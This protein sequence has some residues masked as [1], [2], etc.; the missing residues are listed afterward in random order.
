[1]GIQLQSTDPLTIDIVE[2]GVVTWEDL[3][4]CVRNFHSVPHVS[5]S[6]ISNVWYDRAGSYDAKYAFL[7]HMASLNNVEDVDLKT[8]LDNP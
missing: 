7:K 3:V 6:D 5:S 4:R 2:S 8:R 1:M